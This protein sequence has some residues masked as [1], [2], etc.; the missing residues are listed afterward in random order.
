MLGVD[1][2]AYPTISSWVAQAAQRPSVA[3]ELAVVARL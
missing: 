3:A 2:A 1:L